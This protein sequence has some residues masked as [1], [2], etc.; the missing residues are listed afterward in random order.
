[1]ICLVGVGAVCFVNRAYYGVFAVAE[2]NNTPIPGGHRRAVAA[3][4]PRNLPRTTFSCPR[5][6]ALRAY[7]FSPAF[8]ELEPFLEGP[9]GE[10]FASYSAPDAGLHGEMQ[11]GL[12]WFAVRDSMAAAGHAKSGRD[13][14]EYYATL[15]NE[16]NDACDRRRMRG[17]AAADVPLP[18]PATRAR[19]P[20]FPAAFA[21][22][23]KTLLSMNGMVFEVGPSIGTEQT[24][25]SFSRT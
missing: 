20:Y 10:A 5:K 11:G 8:R 15:A 6:S 7:A 4:N 2:L 16:I 9:I 24:P 23:V 25:A 3:S 18:F 12:F 21:A 1:M 17:E 19:F 13:A 22:T 14:M